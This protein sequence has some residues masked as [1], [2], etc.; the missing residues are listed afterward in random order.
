[1]TNSNLQTEN[2]YNRRYLFLVVSVATDGGFLFGFD[3]M[4]F[5]GAELFLEEHFSLSKLQLGQAGASVVIGALLGT[6]VAALISDWIGRKKAMLLAGF[7][8]LISSVGTA[9]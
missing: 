4:I 1:M 7:L 2:T 5:V 9:I 8:F 3:M 6:L